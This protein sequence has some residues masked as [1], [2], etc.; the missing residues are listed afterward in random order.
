[1]KR[2]AVGALFLSLMAGSVAMAGNGAAYAIR[3]PQRAERPND[4]N[5]HRDEHRDNNWSRDHRSD[6]RR[7]HDRNDDRRFDRDNRHDNWQHDRRNDWHDNWRN[8]RHDNWR[9]DRR[10]DRRDS[11][12]DDHRFDHDWRRDDHNRGFHD[13]WR[14]NGY[15]YG[16]Y[17]RPW[18]YYDHR[19]NRGDRL[20]RAF[21]ARPYV[22]A[23]YRACGLRSPPYGY[24]W[25]RV[26]SDAVLAVIATGVVLDVIYNQ[27]Y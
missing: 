18:G 10:N 27:F 13:D 7:D 16:V 14:Q 4:H 1:M 5:G 12:R 20:P 3:N 23:D 8:D 25:V 11:W 19:W 17:D 15:H 24:H 9:D 26:D 21:Y 22:I 2:V 6:G